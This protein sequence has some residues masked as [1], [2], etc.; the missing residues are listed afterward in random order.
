MSFAAAPR[1]SLPML[2]GHKSRRIRRSPRRATDDAVVC[3]S[4]EE[5]A[6]LAVFAEDG[7]ASAEWGVAVEGSRS[8]AAEILGARATATQV[9][10]FAMAMET[11][12]KS[13]SG[14]VPL[15][16]ARCEWGVLGAP[17]A[18]SVAREAHAPHDVCH[19]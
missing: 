14:G 5:A 10:V 9:S 16:V 6:T 7:C 15:G 4:V 18:K 8:F 12:R 2:E 3:A 19:R 17:K 1:F 13:D 11:H